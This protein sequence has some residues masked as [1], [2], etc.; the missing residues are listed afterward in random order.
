MPHRTKWICLLIL[1][2]FNLAHTQT[3]KDSLLFK[4][5]V[6]KQDTA[7]VQLL[8]DAG[9][10]FFYTHIDTAYTYYKQ[11]LKLSEQTQSKKFKA[12][13]LLNIGYY[14]EEKKQHRKSLEYYLKSISIYKSINNEQGVANCYNYIGYSFAYLNSLENSIKYY[15]KALNIYKKLGDS[16]GI[17]DIYIAFGN[18]HYDQK[19]YKK[20]ENYYIKSLDIYT[21]LKDKPGLLASYINV[22]N[23]KADMGKL[24][25]GL[26][27]YSKSIKLCEELNDKEGLA[28]NYVNI[29]ETLTDKKEYKKAKES[30]D[31]SL[32]ITNKINYTSLLP[33][34]YADYAKNDLKLKKYKKA[35]I[36]AEKSLE[37]SK[38]VDWVDKEYDAHAYLSESYVATGNYKKAYENQKLYTSFTDSI[39]NLKKIE[40][41]SKLDVLTKLEDQEK[42]IE[43]L[44]ENDRIKKAELKNKTTINKVLG[45]SIVLF[46]ILISLLFEQRKRRK[47]AFNLLAVEKKHA[48]ES[49]RLKS[50]FLANMSHEIRTPMNSIIGFSD[51]LK[52]PELEVEKRNKF[53]EVILKSGERLMNIVNDIIDISKIEANQLKIEVQE[54]N[55]TSTL[56]EIIEIQKETNHQFEIKNVDLKLNA[57]LKD[58]FIKTDENRFI[59]IINNLINN[60][61]KFTDKGYVELGYSLK[62]HANKEYVEFYVKD[63]GSGIGKNK[64]NLI[65][66]RFSQAGDKDFKTGNGLGLSICKGIIELLKGKIWVD[67]EIGIGTTFYF[68]LPY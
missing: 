67:S 41:V 66:D 36:N 5:N 68:T 61:I 8:I 10:K 50:A 24:E 26:L 3:F 51:F 25:E 32:E 18:I 62:Q 52:D 29:G 56:N 58:I 28:I 22:G 46:L 65:F 27:Y 43:L 64:F 14:F 13:S 2:S 57:N 45:G 31:K 12:L 15:S 49:D 35:I 38:N 19:N 23:T 20:A 53:V 47:K 30:L 42:K 39:F 48:E 4:L 33:L 54:V 63:T 9:D 1:L 34:I 16:L 6:A 17:A 44:T 40:Q 7:K 11:A 37:F 55:I 21:A 60:A 59:Q